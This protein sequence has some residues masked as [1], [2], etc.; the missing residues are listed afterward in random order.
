MENTSSRGEIV[1]DELASLSQTCLGGLRALQQLQ[2]YYD[3][4]LWDI[5]DPVH[6]KVRHV[7]IHISKTAGHLASLIEP[8]DHDAYHGRTSTETNADEVSKIVADLLMH[9]AQL[10]SAY[11]VELDSALSA[12]YKGNA[13]HFAPGSPLTNFGVSGIG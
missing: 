8:A 12:R 3:S 6:A 5:E 11:G 13:Q 10:A 1:E 2:R 9:A 7:H 4:Q